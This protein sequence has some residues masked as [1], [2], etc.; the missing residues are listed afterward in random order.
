MD[1]ITIITMLCVAGVVWG[2]I[3]FFIR[4]A[5]KYERIKQKNGKE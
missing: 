5:V 1:P 4:K 2:G 3:A